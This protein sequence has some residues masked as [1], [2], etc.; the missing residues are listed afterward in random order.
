MDCSTSD[1]VSTTT[2]ANSVATSGIAYADA[3][4]GRAPKEA[5][6]GMLDTMIGADGDVFARIQPVIETWAGKI[7]HIGAVG[8]GH[9]MKLL[10]NFISLGYPSRPR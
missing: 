3:P 10:N 1:P 4:L 7:L 6:D 8:D 5:W 9:R 2:I